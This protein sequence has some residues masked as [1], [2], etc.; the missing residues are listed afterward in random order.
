VPHLLLPLFQM[1]WKWELHP[2]AWDMA[3]IQPLFKGGNPHA[4]SAE[5]GVLPLSALCLRGLLKLYSNLQAPGMKLSTRGNASRQAGLAS[6]HAALPR[7]TGARPWGQRTHVSV[8][9]PGMRH[10]TLPQIDPLVPL[11]LLVEPQPPSF[12]LDGLADFGI[13]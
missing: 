4:L 11:S 8:F 1:C 7:H 12:F 5:F 13:F 9:R 6:P 3:L 2:A 10:V